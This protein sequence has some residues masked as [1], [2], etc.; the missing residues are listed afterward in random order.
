MVE[1]DS[2]AGER[3]L[4]RRWDARGVA[5]GGDGDGAAVVHANEGGTDVLR[6]GVGIRTLWDVA[7]LDVPPDGGLGGGVLRLRV[8]RGSVSAHGADL[9]GD[10]ISSDSDSD[11]DTVNEGTAESNGV[12][13]KKKGG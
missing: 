3:V 6:D 5:V 13:T 2:G 4:Y 11:A 10:L 12:R 9:L 1:G 8:G 7:V